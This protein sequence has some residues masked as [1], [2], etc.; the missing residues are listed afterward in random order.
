MKYNQDILDILTK[1]NFKQFFEL[2]DYLIIVGFNELDAFTTAL[3]FFPE[4]KIWDGV[5]F[6]VET[7]DTGGLVVN[8]YFS[9]G[10][11][12]EENISLSGLFDVYRE[13]ISK[14]NYNYKDIEDLNQNCKIVIEFKEFNSLLMNYLKIT[15]KKHFGYEMFFNKTPN[16]MPDFVSLMRNLGDDV[17]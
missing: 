1:K 7:Q 17:R 14:G 13:A 15:F 12:G 6:V 2:L 9:I 11:L 10:I 3:K 4:N 8:S 16:R 5:A